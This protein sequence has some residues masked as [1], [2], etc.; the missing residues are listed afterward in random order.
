MEEPSCLSWLN[1]LQNR[2]EPL[3]AQPEDA[4]FYT[5]TVRFAVVESARPFPAPFADTC[6]SGAGGCD[7]RGEGALMA[8]QAAGIGEAVEQ[9]EAAVGAK[10][11][12]PCNC[13]H[14]GVSA[15]ELAWPEAERPAS[16]RAVLAAARARLIAPQYDCLGCELCYPALALN[17]LAQAGLAVAAET[18]A[19][20]PVETREGWPPLPGSYTVRR[21]QA[22]VAVCTLTDDRLSGAL[23]ASMEP[24]LAI[25]GTL[26]T[27][28]LGIERL[29]QNVLANPYIRFLVVCGA[30][31]RQAVGHLPG[32]S[33]LAVSRSGLDGQQRIVG[34]QGRRPFL[35]NLSPEAV[36]HF[37][38]SV[39]VVD[40]IGEDRFERVS[41]LIRACAA[42]DP[43]VSAPFPATSVVAPMPGY[44]PGRMTP[45][46]AGYF[47][48]Y[49]DHNR[50]RLSLEHYRT[51]GLLDTVIEGRSA[52]E[53]YTPAVERG[54]LS[55][56]DHAAYLG[57]E[58]ARA[59]AALATGQPFVQDAAP[60]APSAPSLAPAALSCG[61]TETASGGT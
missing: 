13:F 4:A 22:P 40:A 19:V 33:L 27:E 42:R 58:L 24:G 55:R 41:D 49:A 31:S 45:D 23:A 2:T 46:P 5:R 14:G 17:A 47:V 53:V 21:Y 28:N 48:I 37:R 36:E 15:I 16:V 50:T 6:A 1:N 34:A 18:C 8:I 43:G 9:L 35:R 57:R 38:Q 12:W 52:A 56:L 20:T 44:L 30:D 11:C 26:Q 29:L 10:K 59:E 3:S 61:C 54:L 25:V 51:D 7:D 32:Q 60:E 39:E